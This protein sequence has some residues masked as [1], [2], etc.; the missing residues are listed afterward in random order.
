MD[1]S[2]QLILA[3]LEE[4][5]IQR[6][7]FRIRPLLR[8]AG[9]LTPPQIAEFPDNGFLRIVPDRNEQ[10]TFKDRMRSLGSL[11]V[12]N[13]LGI[14]QEANKIRTNKNYAPE[15]G[16]SNRFIIYSDAV[17]PIPA[18][19]FYEVVAEGSVKD[20]ATPFVYTRV[21]GHIHGPVD[22]ATGE[23]AQNAGQ[24]AP[25][26]PGLF[27]V[28]L[29]DETEKLFYWPSV[30]EPEKKPEEP[31]E[32]KE[33]PSAEGEP[34]TAL[35]K[36]Q[37][38]DEK[39][40]ASINR[41]DAPSSMPPAPVVEIG[42]KLT[43]TP[44]YQPSVRRTAQQRPHNM[45]METVE[46]QR[47]AG[48]YEAPGAQV[49]SGADL[50]NIANPVDAFKA[51]LNNVWR[52]PE[53]QQQ[54]VTAFLS[55]PGSREIVA[56]H[57]SA[58]RQDLTLA[59]MHAQLQ[60]LEAERLMTLMQL[61][62]LKKNAAEARDEALKEATAQQRTEL[63]AL[64][65]E[66]E[67]IR[68]ALEKL[69]AE[70]D[71]L[72]DDR[73]KVLE[74]MEEMSAADD[75]IR[76]APG[77]GENADV[78]TAVSRVAAC[79][80]AK[81]FEGTQEDAAAL[82]IAYALADEQTVGLAAPTEADALDAA[83]AFSHALG[84]SAAWHDW[85]KENVYVYAGGDA[86]AFLLDTVADKQED[87]PYVTLLAAGFEDVSAAACGFVSLKPSGELPTALPSCPPVAA[88]QLKDALTGMQ[89]E[90][91]Q[92]AVRL[93][94]N[95]RAFFEKKGRPLSIRRYAMMHR[96]AAIAQN[97]M[98]SGIAGAL[99]EAVLT[100][101]LPALSEGKQ[102]FAMLC[103]SLPRTLERLNANA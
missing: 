96:F 35:E 86:P 102:E 81:G 7:F 1:F 55:M 65:K 33:Q 93:L 79:L 84:A 9:P 17:Q 13:M 57:I 15:R 36:I 49:S 91:S 50:K 71:T 41:L 51:A 64:K 68:A 37:Q 88:M 29:P 16:E 39:L 31:Q 47:F 5:N 45:L 90:L 12:L 56:R 8:K 92:D 80:K 38:M 28:T 44:L 83:Q 34:M 32:M 11:C 101:A 103:A 99:D 18:N 54:T 19:E 66:T 89:T 21:G 95:I 73:D 46:N 98:D 14:P 20:A 69:K 67:R 52:A 82:L 76:L 72:L 74:K 48:R 61:D 3:Y 24:L 59:A 42:K 58:G 78:Q 23:D 2:D 70:R 97:L 100:Y 25:D 85:K 22:R 4:D 63:D 94:K 60:D 75:V 62:N 77:K 53:T 43:G 40:T 26:S 10:H 27:A 30:T 6:A 87:A